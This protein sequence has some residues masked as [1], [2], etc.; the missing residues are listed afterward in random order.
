MC[1]SAL[2]EVTV[3]FKLYFICY[4]ISCPD[5]P[6]LPNT[7]HSLTQSSRHCS[8]PWVMCISSLLTPFPVL[9]STSLWLFCNYLFVLLNP[10]TSSSI[11]PTSP[12]HLKTI[13]TLCI[14]D[15]VSALVCLLCFLDSM[16]KHMYFWHLTVHIFHLLLFLK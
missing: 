16:L 6:L 3:F 7:P 11:S 2:T 8:C 12:S 5:L 15:S 14:H 1:A 10:L 9:Y 13:K 4:A